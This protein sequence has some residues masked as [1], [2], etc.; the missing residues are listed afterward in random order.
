ML[1]VSLCL[2]ALSLYHVWQGSTPEIIPMIMLLA[3]LTL[4]IGFS[5]ALYRSKP[6]YRITVVMLD[7]AEVTLSRRKKPAA[8]MLLEALT[9]AMD[10]HRMGSIELDAQRSSHLRQGV[11][12]GRQQGP[13][14]ASRGS[15]RTA[16]VDSRSQ[17]RAGARTP[18]RKS[19]R[20]HG[21]QRIR[22]VMRSVVR[23]GREAWQHRGRT[24]QAA[25]SSSE[26]GS[27]GGQARQTSSVKGAVGGQARQTSSEKG[28]VGDQAWQT[29][30][31]RGY[32]AE[33]VRQASY[34]SEGPVVAMKDVTVAARLK[35]LPGR[36]KRVLFR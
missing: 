11:A 13:H 8:V 36:L 27:V 35:E 18:S 19:S 10:W 2:I 1:C 28:A 20:L 30:S 9:D 4:L 22:T 6:L 26:K 3:S 16:G 32:A 17:G 31:D 7:G 25:Q 34:K 23:R 29:S 24:A 21:G 33:H 14:D 15:T 12:H 5:L